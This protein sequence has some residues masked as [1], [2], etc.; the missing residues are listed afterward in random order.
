MALASVLAITLACGGTAAPRGTSTAPPEVTGTATSTAG[1]GATGGPD[2]TAA[3]TAS[4]A[5]TPRPAFLTTTLADVR[6][7]ERFTLGGFSG[8]VTIVLA[9]A[10]W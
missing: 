8:K 7:G 10:V 9:M 1:P 6:T 4:A 3:A 2:V 5:G